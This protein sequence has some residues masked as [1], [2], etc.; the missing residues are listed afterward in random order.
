MN[1]VR[2]FVVGFVLL[3]GTI[4]L[5]IARDVVVEVPYLVRI[6]NVPFMSDVA[7]GVLLRIN[8]TRN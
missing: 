8:N 5:S 6:N 1:I 7:K 2:K 3:G 4:G